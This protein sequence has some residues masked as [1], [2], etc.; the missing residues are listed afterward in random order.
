MPRAVK[1]IKLIRYF[2]FILSFSKEEKSRLHT[3]YQLFQDGLL[4]S[5][6]QNFA[7]ELMEMPSNLMTPRIFADR[8]TQQLSDLENVEVYARY[9]WPFASSIFLS[10]FLFLFS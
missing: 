10:I 4:L 2:H 6:A 9:V 3:W 7:R 5:G 1:R 8:V